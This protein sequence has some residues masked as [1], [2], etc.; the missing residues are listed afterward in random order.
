MS[1][2]LSCQ[3]RQ[4]G[5]KGEKGVFI[6]FKNGIKCYK[7]WDLKDRKFILNRDVTFNEASMVK[8]INSQQV[9]SQTDNRMLQQVESQTAT[10]PSLERSVSFEV[11]P[12]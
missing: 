12:G 5:P 3:E 10:S 2:L 6:G 11:T 9:E 4:V 1:G 7:I 8:L